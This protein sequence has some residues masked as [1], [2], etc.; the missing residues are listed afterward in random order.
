MK[1]ARILQTAAI[2][3]LA[4]LAGGCAALAPK[5]AAVPPPVVS[6]PPSPGQNGNHDTHPAEEIKTEEAKTI[7]PVEERTSAAGDAQVQQAQEKDEA[8][9]SIEDAMTFYEEAVQAQARGDLDT[10]I[11]ALDEAYGII[12]KLNI[13]PDSPIFQ[14]KN[15]LRILISQRIIE[16]NAMRR[17]PI[18]NNHKSFPLVENEFVKKEIASF[19]GPERKA[20]IEGYKRSGLYRAY[21][22]EELRKAGLPEEL[23]WLPLIES[24]FMPQAYSVARALGMWQFIRTTGL[25]YDLDQDKYIDER[26]DPHKSTQ[27]AILYLT[28]LHALFGDWT[29][30]LAGY[31]CGEG[32]VQ[33]CI[34]AQSINYLDNFWDLFKRLPFQT[35]RYVPRLIGAIMIIRDPAKYGLELP[36]PYPELKF[37]TVKISYPTKLAALSTALGLEATE[38]EYLNPELRQ[39]ST[40]E[41]A[42]DLKVPIGFSA[43]ALQA[44]NNVPKY[45]PPEFATHFV[46]SGETL[47]VIARKYGTSVA[48]IQRLNNLRGTMIYPGQTLKIPGRG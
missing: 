12:L 27:A 33:R 7:I 24:W 17:N 18:T 37:E 10:A 1:L 32:Y 9:I 2:I 15:N 23:S 6:A 39:K 35:A 31:N 20:F 13:P 46:R 42:Y 28:D 29:T 14:E 3:L 40:P 19:L 48:M 4:L 30:A 41:T 43:K 5:T 38:L 22:V 21:I 45:V 26:R 44:I 47:S 16:I 25:R 36:E 11:K 34:N 8:T